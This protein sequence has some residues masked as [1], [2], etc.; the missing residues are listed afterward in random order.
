MSLLDLFKVIP[1]VY[2]YTSNDGVET[3]L[4]ETYELT[5]LLKLDPAQVNYLNQHGTFQLD[6]GLIT[7][8]H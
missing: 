6:S 2:T 5:E 8:S 4:T 1:F 3:R 7:V